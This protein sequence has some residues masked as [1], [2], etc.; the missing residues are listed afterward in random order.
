[1][2]WGKPMNFEFIG[3]LARCNMSTGWCVHRVDAA[4]GETGRERQRECGASYIGRSSEAAREIKRLAKKRAEEN[5][6]KTKQFSRYMGWYEGGKERGKENEQG[7]GNCEGCA[8]HMATL[9][10]S[11]DLALDICIYSE[12]TRCS[13]LVVR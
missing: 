12:N 3:I 10:F 5:G 13:R 6:G 11:L 7:G 8:A 1:M 9:S 4:R 2:E